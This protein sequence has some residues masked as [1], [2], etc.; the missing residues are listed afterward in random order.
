MGEG[1]RLHEQRRRRFWVIL[2]WLVIIGM[3]GLVLDGGG[4]F[5][6]RRSEQN[7]IDLAALAGANA[8]LNTSGNAAT[9]TS[10][11]PGL[12]PNTNCRSCAV[13]R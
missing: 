11:R 3:V 10:V 1:E 5:A 13:S 2:G 7:A 12:G 4:A 6:Q 9:R 8:Y